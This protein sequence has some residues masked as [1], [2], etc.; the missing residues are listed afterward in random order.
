[1][2]VTSRAPLT[3]IVAFCVLPLP[4]L[5]LEGL[6][7]TVGGAVAAVADT[8]ARSSYVI[9]GFQTTPRM[10]SVLLSRQV[11]LVGWGMSFGPKKA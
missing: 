4:R 9:P 10:S 7:D 8:R 1:V 3:W 2:S 5:V 6:H 11:M